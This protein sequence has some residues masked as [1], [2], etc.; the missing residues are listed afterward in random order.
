MIFLY[1]SRLTSKS[2]SYKHE[3]APSTTNN[4]KS[5]VSFV[6]GSN[7]GS[8]DT[9]KPVVKNE[10]VPAQP[11]SLQR[12]QVVIAASTERLPLF[13]GDDDTSNDIMTPNAIRLAGAPRGYIPPE[14]CGQGEPDDGPHPVHICYYCKDGRWTHADDLYKGTMH[15]G[16]FTHVPVIE[17][18][19][20]ICKRIQTF[21]DAAKNCQEC[22]YGQL[23]DICESCEKCVNGSCEDDC[24]SGGVC[25]NGICSE[26]CDDS[27]PCDYSQ[28]LECRRGLCQSFCSGVDVCDGEGGCRSPCYPACNGECEECVQ[29]NG[30]YGCRS[31]EDTKSCYSREVCCNGKLKYLRGCEYLDEDCNVKKECDSLLCEVGVNGCP[32]CT[33]RCVTDADCNVSN[34]EVCRKVPGT[35]A[36]YQCIGCELQFPGL[37]HPFCDGKGTCVT[38]EECN[39]CQRLR[40]KPECA[41]DPEPNIDCLHCVDVCGERMG[42]DGNPLTCAPDPVNPA[43]VFC[44]YMPE[45]IIASIIP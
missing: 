29:I 36:M 43:E 41:G 5:T 1:G 3:S 16:C 28:C 26:R 33:T 8:S 15:E 14:F 40:V 24:P 30:V 27:T 38:P 18:G 6:S 44:Q 45:V 35:T 39:G 12:G 23:E 7:I 9:S 21:P 10:A 19:Q 17:N 4:L 31:L 34:C 25:Y 13:D 37:N 42:P 2:K 32:Y 20:R 11:L 22:L